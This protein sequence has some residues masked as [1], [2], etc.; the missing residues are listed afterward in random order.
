[1]A[2]RLCV[3]ANGKFLYCLAHLR[4]SSAYQLRV[5]APLRISSSAYQLLRI[6]STYQRLRSS[7]YRLFRISA[8][9]VRIIMAT[10]LRKCLQCNLQK[11][12]T[13]FLP[14]YRICLDCR[15]Q[16]PVLPQQIPPSDE[17]FPLNTEHICSSCQVLRV[18]G[19]RKTGREKARV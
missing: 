2:S 10:S 17:N 5:P 7:A 1:M 13:R 3:I 14:R 6:P 16:Q 8:Y 15:P 12:T 19:Q 4:T 9:K 18:K 11:N